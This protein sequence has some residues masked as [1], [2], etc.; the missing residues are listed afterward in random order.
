MHA[1]CESLRFS[2]YRLLS[3]LVFRGALQVAIFLTVNQSQYRIHCTKAPTART[4]VY[5]C[6]LGD[7]NRALLSAMTV[8][9]RA[10]PYPKSR[11]LLLPYHGWLGRTNRQLLLLLRDLLGWASS[12]DVPVLF[13]FRLA[14]YSPAQPP[15]LVSTSAIPT[16]SA[17]LSDL[18]ALGS[19]L[20][21]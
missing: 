11:D 17:G 16:S 10:G 13:G 5:P 6:C 4:I 9:Y 21:F 15:W 18:A 1:D 3:I 7:H 20:A 14:D 19:R 2:S 8:V 12:N